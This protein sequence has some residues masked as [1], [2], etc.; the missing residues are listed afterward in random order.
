MELARVSDVKDPVGS[1]R[2]EEWPPA[3]ALKKLR[4]CLEALSMNPRAWVLGGG[5]LAVLGMR[6]DLQL[7]VESRYDLGETPTGKPS[8]KFSG[9]KVLDPIGIMRNLEFEYAISKPNAKR[10]FMSET[11]ALRLGN[12]R[13]A[14]YN[15]GG[16]AR[17]RMAYI[18]TS[19][20]LNEWLDDWLDALKI[21][22]KKQSANRKV[23]KVQTDLDLMMGDTWIG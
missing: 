12:R 6:S 22:H 15:D 11:D 5:Q 17:L 1:T 16:Q 13:N 23:K 8:A 4:L 18:D 10:L 3:P 9:A 14:L 19:T 20:E 21:D 2:I 7:A